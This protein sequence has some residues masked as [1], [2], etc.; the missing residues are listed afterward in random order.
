MLPVA[1]GL[2]YGNAK[3]VE[4]ISFRVLRRSAL[5]GNRVGADHKGES[6][7]PNFDEASGTCRGHTARN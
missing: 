5:Q 6:P 7:D 3:M 4:R 1:Y 2:C